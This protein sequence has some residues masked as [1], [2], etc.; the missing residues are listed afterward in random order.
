M[1]QED[2]DSIPKVIA[3]CK[4]RSIELCTSDDA[5]AEIEKLAVTN[6][7]FRDKLMRHLHNFHLLPIKHHIKWSNGH[8]WDMGWTWGGETPS[9][10][11][12]LVDAISAFLL[13]KTRITN[14]EKQ[15]SVRWDACHLAVCKDK[16]CE[17][18]LPTDYASIWAHRRALRRQ[19]GIE[20]CRPVDLLS[21]L[22]QTR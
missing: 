13:R 21:R 8:H 10:T 14:P 19:F 20:V 1:L 16:N 17:I 18:F 5:G 11:D 3:L 2:T 9:A 22:T 15:E 7:E 12:I 6:P 4:E